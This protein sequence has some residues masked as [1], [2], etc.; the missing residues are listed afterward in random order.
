MPSNSMKENSPKFTNA[1]VSGFMHMVS[2]ILYCSRS[3]CGSQTTGSNLLNTT[4][5]ISPNMEVTINS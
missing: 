2:K 5:A 4:C 3:M 1:K